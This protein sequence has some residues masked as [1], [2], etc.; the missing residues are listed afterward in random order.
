MWQHRPQQFG[1]AILAEASD[2]IGNTIEALIVGAYGFGEAIADRITPSGFLDESPEMLS[3]IL[4]FALSA[5]T[6]EQPHNIWFMFLK[7]I[8][9]DNGI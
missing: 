7:W 2:V 4:A 8:C 6:I 9:Y 5:P 3:L 1:S